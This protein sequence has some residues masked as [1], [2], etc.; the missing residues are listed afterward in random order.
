MN[1]LK[2]DP[3]KE[4][5]I[6]MLHVRAIFSSQ[7]LPVDEPSGN[8]RL[9]D[10]LIVTIFPFNRFLLTGD[11]TGKDCSILADKD[12]CSEK[13]QP[14][15]FAYRKWPHNRSAKHLFRGPKLIVAYSS[16]TWLGRV[17]MM[18]VQRCCVIWWGITAPHRQ[19]HTNSLL[20]LNVWF[21][22]ITS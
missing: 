1:C 3:E 9:T 4:T 5:Y 17:S 19:C 12:P 11:S 14:L 20:A 13:K 18:T 6:K 16:S 8:G 2:F 15:Q 21:C 22:H 10:I 7:P